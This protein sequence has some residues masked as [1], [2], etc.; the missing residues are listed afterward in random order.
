MGH[1]NVGCRSA[2]EVVHL[3]LLPAFCS[4]LHG[5][6]CQ[7]KTLNHKTLHPQWHPLRPPAD[8]AGR[9]QFQIRVP[10]GR[11]GTV[12][13]KNGPDPQI[14]EH[15]PN[16]PPTNFPKSL[17]AQPATRN[18][19]SFL[20][21]VASNLMAARRLKRAFRPE[22]SIGQASW[23]VSRRACPNRRL[24]ALSPSRLLDDCWMSLS[25]HQHSL[26][27]TFMTKP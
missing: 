10:D 6:A 7:P 9:L 27:G 23:Q 14:P 17:E 19:R 1:A 8:E 4:R 13:P 3:P 15:V 11:P 20:S 24:T 21:N 22:D 26:I 5:L 2:N 25:P 12:V 18:S 16:P